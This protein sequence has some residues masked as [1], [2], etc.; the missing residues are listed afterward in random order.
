MRNSADFEVRDMRISEY[1]HSML[2]QIKRTT[3]DAPD[4]QSIIIASEDT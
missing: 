3:P 4:K 2:Y 1:L